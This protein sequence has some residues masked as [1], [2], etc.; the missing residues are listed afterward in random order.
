MSRATVRAMIPHSKGQVPVF[1]VLEVAGGAILNVLAG[2]RLAPEAAHG[3]QHFVSRSWA[4]VL[5]SLCL[6]PI[7]P[8]EVAANLVDRAS[9]LYR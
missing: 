1:Q 3:A 5:C 8:G 6:D 2:L 9:A 4:S 7:P